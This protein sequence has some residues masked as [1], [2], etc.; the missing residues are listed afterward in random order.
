MQ[1]IMYNKMDTMLPTRK[2]VSKTITA[3][4]HVYFCD[5]SDEWMKAM[6]SQIAPPKMQISSN[7]LIIASLLWMK[8]KLTC[9][10]VQ[11]SIIKETASMILM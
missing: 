2:N 6:I 5:K 1:K 7:K 4:N 9:H 10:Q 8:C 3:P 11:A